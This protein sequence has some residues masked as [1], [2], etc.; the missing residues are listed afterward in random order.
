MEAYITTQIEILCS[1]P[2]KETILELAKNSYNYTPLI[3]LIDYLQE[4]T[5][6]NKKYGLIMN[7]LLDDIDYY[8]RIKIS[9]ITSDVLY[10]SVILLDISRI[11]KNPNKIDNDDLFTI[12]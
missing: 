1:S 5:D 12:K 10:R 2:A 11:A 7:D 3:N 9:I 4:L 6:K 8:Q